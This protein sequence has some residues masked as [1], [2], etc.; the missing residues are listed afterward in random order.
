MVL[1]VPI[2]NPFAD[3]TANWQDIYGASQRRLGTINAPFYPAPGSVGPSQ[4]PPQGQPTPSG[5]DQN[6]LMRLLGAGLPGADQGQGQSSNDQPGPVPAGLPGAGFTLADLNRLINGSSTSGD[7]SAM[8]P[9]GTGRG[10]SMSDLARLSG[11]PAQLASIAGGFAGL[12]LG[13]LVQGAG[14]IGNTY[15]ANDILSQYG[16]E[17]NLGFGSGLSDFLH[18]VTFGL[19][20]TS[21]NQ[22]ALN[23]TNT[24]DYNQL[25]A[26]TGNP[27]AQ[28][29]AWDAM[30][31]QLQQY[32]DQNY[33]P[34]A[35][36]NYGLAPGENLYD[37]PAAWL[38]NQANA[39]AYGAANYGEY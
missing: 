36:Q 31:A 35:D 22:Q 26:Q 18:A 20:G 8:P 28:Q 27:T 38:D 16:L 14:S 17:R 5:F 11:R 7:S 1:E 37:A 25:L 15:A 12:P 34:T 6:A 3:A 21:A 24:V 2:N 39:N 30:N 10:F 13:A 33:G 23:Q 32:S 19:L 9:G 29:A 4:G